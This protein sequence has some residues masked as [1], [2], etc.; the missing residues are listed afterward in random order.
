[1]LSLAEAVQRVYAPFETRP[2]TPELRIELINKLDALFAALT[3][4]GYRV[5]EDFNLVINSAGGTDVFF[6][7]VFTAGKEI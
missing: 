5:P 3:S 7:K 2:S 4:K 1:M 6:S